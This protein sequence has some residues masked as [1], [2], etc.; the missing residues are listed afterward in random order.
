MLVLIAGARRR[1]SL[2]NAPTRSAEAEIQQR[3]A[4]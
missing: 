3:E 2:G 1:R 4:Q